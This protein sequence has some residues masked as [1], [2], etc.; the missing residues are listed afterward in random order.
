MRYN[1][2]NKFLYLLV[3]LILCSSCAAE[4]FNSSKSVL[5]IVPLS[6]NT[7]NK[8]YDAFAECFAD[9]LITSLNEQKSVKVIERQKLKKLLKEQ[10]LLLSGLT[11][12]GTAIKVGKLI[13]ANRIIVGG[14]SKP[15]DN[16]IINVHAYET[17][18]ARLV[19]SEQIEARP[20]EIMP[21]TIQL[22]NK[23]CA[24]LNIELNPVDPNNIDKN[25]NASLHFIRG[26]GFFYIGH[27]DNAIIEFMKTQDLDSDSDKAGYWMALC[28]MEDKEYKHALIE[29]EALI[30]DFPESDLMQDI[31]EKI[32]LCTKY[33][34][35]NGS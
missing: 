2:K 3:S 14:I 34:E 27:Y 26:L 10:K 18:T 4:Y 32:Q 35:K 1:K 20:E 17:E 25:P 22:V 29:L 16:F 7:D 23:L 13:K 5:C 6:N 21:A 15:K 30:Q 8:Q 28:F 9:I 24:K 12:S 19:A 31:Q 11:D 33:L